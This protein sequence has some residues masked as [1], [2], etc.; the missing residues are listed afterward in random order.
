MISRAQACLLVCWAVLRARVCVHVCAQVKLTNSQKDV[1]DMAQVEVG[2]EV[3][4]IKGHERETENN[5]DPFLTPF[6]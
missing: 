3:K 4:E 2:E 5:T 1:P 6:T